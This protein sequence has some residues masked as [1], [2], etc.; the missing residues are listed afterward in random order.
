MARRT[1]ESH[2]VATQSAQPPDH[3]SGLLQWKSQRAQI[4][5][6]TPLVS[7]ISTP[8]GSGR[9]IS[10][11]ATLLGG[12]TSSASPAYTVKSPRGPLTREAWVPCLAQLKGGWESNFCLICHRLIPPFLFLQTFMPGSICKCI[13]YFLITAVLQYFSYQEHCV[14]P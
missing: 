2:A 4:P 9:W 6:A 11:P 3:P 5:H 8:A 10:S 12:S 1:R 13:D 14:T 7:R